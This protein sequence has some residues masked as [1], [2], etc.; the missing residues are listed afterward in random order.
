MKKTFLSKVL[1]TALAVQG[2]VQARDIRNIILPEYAPHHYQLDRY[3]ALDNEDKECGFDFRVWGTGYFRVANQAFSNCDSTCRVPLSNI[4]FGASDFTVAQAFPNGIASGLVDNPFVSF[5]TITPRYEYEEKGAVLSAEINR[6]FCEDYHVGLRARLPIRNTCM[7]E[8]CS[9]SDLQGA[10]LQDV[11]QTRLETIGTETPSSTSTDPQ[12]TNTVFAAR[13]DFLSSIDRIAITANGSVQPM[14]NYN[15]APTNTGLTI[16]E[17]RV[18]VAPTANNNQP[19]IAVIGRVDGSMPLDQRWGQQSGATAYGTG[20]TADVAAD[21]S[22]VGNNVR[23]K[24]VAATDYASLGG[25]NLAQSKLFVVPTLQNSPTPGANINKLTEGAVAILSAIQAVQL[26]NNSVTSFLKDTGID[27]C[28]GRSQ[29]LGDLDLELYLAREWLCDKSLLTEVQFAVRVPTA[30]KLCDC[31]KVLVQPLGNNGH[32]ELRL[33]VLGAYDWTSWFKV[34][35]DFA[36]SWVLEGCESVAA[37][38]KG[39]TIKNVGPCINANVKWDYLWAHIDLSFFASDC[40]GF[41]VGYEAYHKSCDTICSSQTTATD[42]AGNVNQPLDFSLLRKYT[43][44]TN[45]KIYAEGF[46]ASGNCEL[47]VGFGHSVAGRNS[48]RDADWYLGLQVTF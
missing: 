9:E 27:I 18:D 41:N 7:S 11:F 15:P 21:G 5:S 36:Y 37:P 47:F 35:A 33:G 3:H 29:G 4:I 39:A 12:Q 48:M 17:Q 19:S 25:N 16:A 46:M 38:F 14:V 42:L 23:G 40:C 24:F 20:I 28:S 34:K 44:A 22:G 8:M 45:H 2:W 6:D 13:L 31:R 32:T 1:L 10:T 43:D 26:S 30:D